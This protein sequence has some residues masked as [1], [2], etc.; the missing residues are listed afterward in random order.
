M[1][2]SD[3]VFLDTSIAIALFI[4]PIE[5]KTEIRSKLK[6]F[7]LRLTGLV[8]LQEFSRRLLKEAKYLLDQLRSKGSYQKV[9]SH[10][11]FLPPQSQRKFKI[12]FSTMV[13]CF[14]EGSDSDRTDRMTYFL[15][16]L[17]E[18]GSQE[19]LLNVVDSVVKDVGCASS[20]IGIKKTKNTFR[21]P[22]DK[23][24]SHASCGVGEFLRSCC[25]RNALVDFLAENRD[26]LTS[27][28]ES[29]LTALRQLQEPDCSNANALNPCLKF[30]DVLISL[31]SRGAGAFITLNY[32][33]SKLLCK[34]ADQEM[35]VVPVNPDKL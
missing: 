5:I 4:H 10:L 15:E 23:C 33:E 24:Q 32:K 13:N 9:L 29:G 12:C 34:Q 26:E 8:V 35:I 6:R 18:C 20:S 28:L 1:N 22:S 31:E 21:F 17:L 19:L 30:G 14:P 27:E 3:I 25:N 2:R 7:Q 16:D 11:Q